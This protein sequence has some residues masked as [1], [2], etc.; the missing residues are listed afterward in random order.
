[1]SQKR[2]AYLLSCVLAAPATVAAAAAEPVT[3]AVNPLP[4]APCFAPNLQAH[5]EPDRGDEF[6][7]ALG[8]MTLGDE[9][10]HAVERLAATY[11]DQLGVSPRPLDLRADEVAFHNHVKGVLSPE[12]REELDDR[13]AQLHTENR[14]IST[15]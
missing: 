13:L 8:T 15:L 7:R 5:Q 4:L 3:G 14:V 9:Q 10:R 2:L 11:C 6:L 12:Q 1:M